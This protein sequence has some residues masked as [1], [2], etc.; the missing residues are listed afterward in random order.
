M[1]K[2]SPLI[3]EI[4][5]ISHLG[6]RGD[7]LTRLS[8]ETLAVPYTLPGERIQVQRQ[9]GA[10]E[11]KLIEIISASPDRVIPPCPHFTHCGGCHLQHLN[12]ELY[13]SFKRDLVKSALQG[14][15]L[16]DLIVL[17]PIIFQPKTRRRAVFKAFKK[18][19]TLSLGF[20]RRQSHDIINLEFCPLLDPAL[21]GLINP[22]RDFLKLFLLEETS[23]DIFVTQSD[24]GL[25]VL[26][27]YKNKPTL[28]LDNREQ[29]IQFAATYNLARLS[30]TQ[31][32]NDAATPDVIV[33][34]R[35]PTIHFD[36]VPVHMDAK[37]F[38]QA[39]KDMDR[40]VEDYIKKTL[41]FDIKRVADLFCG[42]GTLSFPLST[43]AMVDGFEMEQDALTA[44]QMAAHKAQ[45]P[46]QVKERN[47][48]HDPLKTKEL[49]K[50]TCVSINPP[51]VGAAKQMKEL[52][53]SNV[54]HIFMMSCNPISFAKDVRILIEGGY[55]P[56][57]IT[58]ID[59]FLWSPHVEMVAVFSK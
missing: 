52:A 35:T 26:F 37:S 9:S 24:V 20:Y 43:I 47:L 18:K 11:A 36:G 30:V 59:Q 38:L 21:E 51:R 54:P 29:L 41:T 6:H 23:L 53:Q 49:E 17:D 45:R 4:A 44:L 28:S 7:G 56:S 27:S 31:Q 40:F 10:G 42:R 48:F 14:Q 39:S 32:R 58:P 1:K 57:P 55:R 13:Q 25:D 5:E 50:Y 34:F 8:N 12:S 19:N 16:S 22:L 2:K 33:N 46:I 15:G 3:N